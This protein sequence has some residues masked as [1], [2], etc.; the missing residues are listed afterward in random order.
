MECHLVSSDLNEFLGESH[1]YLCLFAWNMRNKTTSVAYD[2]MVVML[3]IMLEERI[4]WSAPCDHK[5]LKESFGHE[6]P[7]GAIHTRFVAVGLPCYLTD[8]KWLVCR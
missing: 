5:L 6:H 7:N 2:M 1:M 3:I 8:S 4:A